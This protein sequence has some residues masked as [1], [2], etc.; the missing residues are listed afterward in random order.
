VIGPRL[1][2][3]AWA[4]A[5]AVFAMGIF[6]S[7]PFLTSATGWGDWQWFHHMWEAGRIGYVRW[8]EVP[9]WNPYHCGGAQLWG[10]P[11]AQVYSPTYLVFAI[12]FGTNLGHKLFILLHGVAGY[13]GMYLLA[14]WEM[15][16]GRP[17]SFFAATVWCA[18]GA[19]AWH[20][21]G[22]HA[23]F[24]A[25]YYAP[26][27]MLAWRATVRDVRWAPAAAAMMTLTIFEGGHYP[28]PYFV[29]WIAFDAICLAAGTKKGVRRVAKAAL[30]AGGLT[31]LLSAMRVVPILRAI[32]AHPHPV[33][34]TDSLTFSEVV[35]ML[36]A[37]EHDYRFAGHAWSWPE[38]G[39]YVGWAVLAM[40]VLGSVIAILRA[41]LARAHRTRF[42]A[43]CLLTGLLLFFLLTQGRASEHHPWPLLQ[44]LPF[45]RSIHVPSRFRV[46]LIFYVALLGGVAIDAIGAAARSLPF[47]SEL[48]DVL[49]ALP[50]TIALAVALDMYVVNLRIINR[51]DGA[52][53]G[54]HPVSLHHH[55]V[56]GRQYFEEYANYPSENVG[57]RECYD[58]VPWDVSSALWLGD[59]PQVRIEPESAGEVVDWGRTNLTM[60]AEV[61]LREPAR[62]VFNQNAA[63]DWSSP[64]GRVTETRGLMAV[65]VARAG[66]QRVTARFHPADLPWSALASILGV[67]L[68]IVVW[69]AP[70]RGRRAAPPR[71]SGRGRGGGS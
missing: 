33:P 6:W 10:N 34:D 25:F 59:E 1:E 4:V 31:G 71:A 29:L 21:A 38:Y 42:D 19:F 36:T 13:A 49:V 18:S 64:Q 65:D 14:R 44:E 22:G 32:L 51:W 60:W 43:I 41:G 23:T 62:L 66:P 50:W 46:M 11:Q 28:F 35:E 55:L 67:F 70:W 26:L 61:D 3:T 9:L 15:R 12:P 57:T 53:I 24:L 63:P 47:R 5:L 48:R 37:R 68:S 58:P 27:V 8:H 30:V 52:D 69:L 56:R 40:L 39:A 16:L 20:V 45:Y 17:A 7:P 2:R 54:N